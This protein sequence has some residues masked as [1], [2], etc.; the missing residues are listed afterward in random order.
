MELEGF[1]ERVLTLDQL[2]KEGRTGNIDELAAKLQ[3]SKRQTFKYLK[4]LRNIGRNNAFDQ[5]QQSYIY[6][7]DQ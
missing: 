5:K 3:L 7:K 6:L 4:A 2:L 1:I